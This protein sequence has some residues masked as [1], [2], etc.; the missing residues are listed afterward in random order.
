MADEL[1]ERYNIEVDSSGH[2]WADQ[3][4]PW[5]VADFLHF[6][7]D[8]QKTVL[9][10]GLTL[11]FLDVLGGIQVVIHSQILLRNALMIKQATNY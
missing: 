9:M 8:D 7:Q 5:N 11:T 1:K 6:S 2:T 3:P 4:T 10:I